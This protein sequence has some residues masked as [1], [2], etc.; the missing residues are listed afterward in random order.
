M[1]QA[2]DLRRLRGL[3][4]GNDPTPGAAVVPI[5]A[6]RPLFRGTVAPVLQARFEATAS[7]LLVPLGTMRRPQPIDQAKVYLTAEESLDQS[8]SVDVLDRVLSWHSLEDVLPWTAHW[9]AKLRRP[10]ARQQDVDVE[11]A[12]TY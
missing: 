4:A 1:D 7:G 2:D 12:T 10:G 3:V 8:I 11:F 9:I 5:Y 6:D